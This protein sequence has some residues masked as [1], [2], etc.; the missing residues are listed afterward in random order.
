VN[1]ELYRKP[2]GTG[3]GTALP[4]QCRADFY[5]A[6]GSGLSTN[7]KSV[8]DA[9]SGPEVKP[10]TGRGM[11]TSTGTALPSQ[12]WADFYLAAGS[13]LASNTKSAGDASTGPEVKPIT[14]RGM[15][16][17]T[18]TALPSQHWYS[19]AVTVLGRFLF[20]CWVRAGKQHQIGG[21]RQHRTR[22]KTYYWARNGYQ[23]WYSTA[24]PALVQ[25]CCSST[26]TA[27]PSQHS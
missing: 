8:G 17:S 14:G 27:L 23:H 3:A 16:T 20:G 6:A 15:A 25:H 22:S 4:S 18:G 7:T 24:V 26:G 2:T 10:I 21:G 5:L 1:D 13:G 11:A 9:S 12:F 19:T